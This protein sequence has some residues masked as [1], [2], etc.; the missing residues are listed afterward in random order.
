MLKKNI[1]KFKLPYNDVINQEDYVK[2]IHSQMII[3]RAEILPYPNE[4]EYIA[5]SDLFDSIPECEIIPLY[6]VIVDTKNNVKVR[7]AI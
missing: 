2:Q 5:L 7:H 6:Y 3:A 4:I 1:G